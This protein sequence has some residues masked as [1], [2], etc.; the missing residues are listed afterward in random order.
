MTTVRKMMMAGIMDPSRLIMRF[1]NLLKR[2]DLQAPLPEIGAR[3]D[4]KD[5]ITI[6]GIH[7][8]Q[9]VSPL[10]PKWYIFWL[11]KQLAQCVLSKMDA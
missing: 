11:F 7:Q 10:L 2:W 5:L 8:R 1:A 3:P 9:G 6:I 4:Q